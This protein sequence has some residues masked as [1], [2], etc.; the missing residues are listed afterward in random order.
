MKFNNTFANT[1]ANTC[2]ENSWVIARQYD[3]K[4]VDFDKVEQCW[5]DEC[6]T[7]NY[8]DW[9]YSQY[10]THMVSVCEK[11]SWVIYQTYPETNFKLDD[12]IDYF[13]E[14]FTYGFAINDDNES[15]N[16]SESTIDNMSDI[17]NDNESEHDITA[18]TSLEEI[19]EQ[20]IGSNTE[21]AEITSEDW[22]NIAHQL[23]FY[24]EEE[25]QE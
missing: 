7:T 16:M 22:D 11:Y 13:M 14:I 21:N 4:T 20:H 10:V 19:W 9:T 12:L 8:E 1:F 18:S 6:T 5:R 2:K 23:D 3:N 25:H 15:D 24:E 17:E